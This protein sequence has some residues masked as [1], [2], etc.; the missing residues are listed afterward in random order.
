MNEE[1]DEVEIGETGLE[2]TMS[3]K[4]TTQEPKINMIFNT[5]DEVDSRSRAAYEEFGDAITFDTTYLTNKYDMPFATFVGVN[6]HRHS[7]LLGCGLISSEDTETFVWLFK[8]WLA[9]MSGHAPCGIIT[10]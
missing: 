1:N 8:V 10:D 2:N 4:E 6:H 9:C 7:I 3:P 5:A